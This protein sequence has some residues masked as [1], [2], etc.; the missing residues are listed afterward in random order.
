MD[1][2]VRATREQL[3]ECCRKAR[4]RLALARQGPGMRQAGR[5]S[6]LV[7]FLLATQD[8]RNSGAAGAR[9]AP[10]LML[11]Q[12]KTASHSADTFQ[13]TRSRANPDPNPGGKWQ[14]TP[15]GRGSKAA[16]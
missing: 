9:N 1:A 11:D 13:K 4:P 2:G 3:P 12:G 10:A 14:Q 7:P 16:S 5:P 15:Q 8:E 6:L